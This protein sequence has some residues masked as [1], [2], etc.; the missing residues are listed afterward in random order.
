M[1]QQNASSEGIQMNAEPSL[2]ANG[3][4][5]HDSS[6]H[7]SLEQDHT[8]PGTPG[9][10]KC[11][12]ANMGRQDSAFT[13]AHPS[14]LPTPPD[15]TKDPLADDPIAADLCAAPSSVG[16]S[17]CPIR[18]LDAHSPEEVAEYFENHKHEIPRSHAVCV[19]RYSTDATRAARIDALY[20]ANLANMLQGL[21]H[22]HQPLLPPEERSRAVAEASTIGSS[23]NAASVAKPMENVE[24]W[25]EKCAET[26]EKAPEDDNNV[27]ESWDSGPRA[28]EED[29][30][31][32][33]HFERP[34]HDVRL[35]ESPSRPW[36]IQVPEA[37]EP[38]LSAADDARS[39]ASRPRTIPGTIEGEGSAHEDSAHEVADANNAPSWQ[40]H[41]SATHSLSG[42]K[43]I[44]NEY[45]ASG[46][47]RSMPV[48]KEP[49]HEQRNAGPGAVIFNGPVFLGYSAEDAAAL[50]QSYT[51][52]RP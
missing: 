11:P 20:G 15:Y 38:P 28:G 16:G 48:K 31:R 12:F 35:G 7:G 44:P 24:E 39:H 52:S 14:S 1:L 42:D 26:V 23:R 25:A 43:S 36:G 46:S 40:G 37:H 19:Q 33:P 3:V 4:S 41:R 9:N 47:G 27:A 30:D 29:G 8:T 6:K 17:K 2:F 34:L 51:N 45:P 49:M 5:V 13:K 18:F 22:K 50:L 32:T 21:G 10:L